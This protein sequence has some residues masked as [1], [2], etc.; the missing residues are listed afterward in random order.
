MT[1]AG[2]GAAGPEISIVIPAY[3]EAARLATTL[4]AIECHVRLHALD[5][6]V[7]VVDDGSRDTTAKLVGAR[8]AGWLALRLIS[9]PWNQGKGSAVRLGM[10]AARGRYC[11]FSDADLSV[12]ISD[13]ETLLAPLRS[14]AAV[15]IASRRLAASDVQVHQPW[16]RETMGR[17]FSLLV[18]TFVMRGIRDTQCGFK[19]FTAEAAREVFPPLQ[20]PGFGFDVEVLYRA[21]LAGCRIVEVPARWINSPQTTVRTSQGLRAFLELLVIRRRVARHPSRPSLRA[22]RPEPSPSSV[23][24]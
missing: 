10:A 16:T 5:A 21:R 4:D 13:L 22:S 3:N 1:A 23:S 2:S 20:T 14:G 24:A 8:A 17:V 18:R 12:P 15:A 9:S 19:A 11:V 7:I 6:E